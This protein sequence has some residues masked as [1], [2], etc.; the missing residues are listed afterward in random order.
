M[1]LPDAK[2][3]SVAVETS[4]G[5]SDRSD[6]L[7][8]MMTCAVDTSGASGK[9]AVVSTKEAK[10]S[11]PVVTT[12]SSNVKTLSASKSTMVTQ[13]LSPIPSE[14]A[15]SST[16][17]E[18]VTSKKK[19]KKSKKRSSL[20]KGGTSAS[21]C[22]E[23]QAADD[24]LMSAN[25]SKAFTR[26]ISQREDE[27]TEEI[28]TNKVDFASASVEED[29]GV[30]IS[31]HGVQKASDDASDEF[32]P[33]RRRPVG[34]STTSD[35]DEEDRQVFRRKSEDDSSESGNVSR[36][37][38]ASSAKP[39]VPTWINDMLKNSESSNAI[40]KGIET[41]GKMWEDSSE[42]SHSGGFEVRKSSSSS[43][44][45]QLPQEDQSSEDDMEFRPAL[46][47]RQ[48]KLKMSK[49][50]DES[51]HIQ[52][53]SRAGSFADSESSLPMSRS[54]DEEVK[55][56]P[57][58]GWSFEADDLDVDK[59]IDEVVG[60]A[61]AANVVDEEKKTPLDELFKFDS[62]LALKAGDAGEDN[63]EEEEED[64]D[65]V[66][67]ARK[68][69]VSLDDLNDALEEEEEEENHERKVSTAKDSRKMTAS[70]NVSFDEESLIPSAEARK[71]L[72]TAT[73][74]SAG[75]G[76][77]SE[78]SVGSSP[79][80]KKNKGKRKKKKKGF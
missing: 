27:K 57:K 67:G 25:L 7:E 26:E 76:S 17:S 43:S 34:V 58:E 11:S 69:T 31:S 21:S 70:L 4:S 13:S 20:S 80:P 14:T 49:S 41:A 23:G 30:M 6:G 29:N 3:F 38:Q 79:N 66:E 56:D 5:V 53:R 32:M 18:N 72:S 46:S 77:T 19:G 33:A 74:S 24:A 48:R 40:L 10:S 2:M 15:S 39:S 59:L 37:P 52:I 78:S 16:A 42:M 60:G 62:E 54:L 73:S 9:F 47:R 64:D 71:S 36:R 8:A 1:T 55:Q 51:S 50:T 75:V 12:S 65:K 61:A 44:S 45:R 63:D 22:D 35:D 28:K 68:M